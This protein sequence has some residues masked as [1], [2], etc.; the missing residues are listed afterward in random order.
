[1][2]APLA[3]AAGTLASR[4]A[5]WAAPAVGRMLFGSVGR[6][7]TTGLVA[8]MT[9][10]DGQATRGLLGSAFDWAT[11]AGLE[12]AKDLLN[13]ALENPAQAAG[14]AGVALAVTALLNDMIG[15]PLALIAGV[16]LALYFKPQIG[17]M[18]DSFM[19]AA[20]PEP[21]PVAATSPEYEQGLQEL[22][23]LSRGPSPQP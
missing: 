6:A 21:A 11:G 22:S 23:R 5:L 8:D 20:Q 4:F 10:N 3:Y 13:D 15:G 1:M 14:M 17:S 18:I 2:V 7:A 9:L 12:G 19:G 16:A